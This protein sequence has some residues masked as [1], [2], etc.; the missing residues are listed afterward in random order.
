MPDTY[1]RTRPP[2]RGR[3]TVASPTTHRR[4]RER[5]IERDPL[6]LAEVHDEF[7]HS[8]LGV[9]MR[10]TRH[11]QT[12]E[13]V[14]QEVFLVLWRRPESFDP[15]R[16]SMRTWLF[17]VAR[18]RA[19]DAV[20][21][22]EAAR[23]RNNQDSRRHIEHVPDVG[24]SFEASQ[25]AV[26]LWAAVARLDENRRRAIMLAYLEG[27]SYRQV[28]AD[29]GVAEGTVKSRIRAGLRELAIALPSEPIEEAC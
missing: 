13:D 22:E 25:S 14:A 21:V 2:R 15:D 17:T 26:S 16:G 23:R 8:V 19:I 7:H 18:R 12:A 24:D 5:L 1:I 28:A 11:R 27:R 9:A 10:V 29:L 6:A 3:A 20:R 4:L